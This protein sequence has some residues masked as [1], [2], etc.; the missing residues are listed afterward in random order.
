MISKRSAG[1][2]A[3]LRNCVRLELAF[4]FVCLGLPRH[5]QLGNTGILFKLSLGLQDLISSRRL[6]ASNM[7][8]AVLRCKV[9]NPRGNCGSPHLTRWGHKSRRKSRNNECRG[10]KAQAVDV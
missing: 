1:L 2:R 9:Q 8:P 5:L 10:I 6:G 4:A 7:R 3:A